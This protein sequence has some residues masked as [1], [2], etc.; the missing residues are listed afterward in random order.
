MAN[1]IYASIWFFILWKWGDW[2]NWQKYYPTILFFILGDF[3]YLYLLS[4]HYPMWRYNPSEGDRAH[5]L[6]NSHISLSIILIKYPATALIFLSKFPE[7]NFI[8]QSLY[9]AFWVFLYTVNELI[10]LY[11]N[12]IKYYNGWNLKWSI[13]FNFVMFTCLYIHFR[14]PFIAWIFSIVFILFLWKTFDVPSNVFR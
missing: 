8:K 2:K 6:T 13:V 3:I 5:G 14:K 10:D 9:I 4:D 11:F 12:L 1:A 7:H